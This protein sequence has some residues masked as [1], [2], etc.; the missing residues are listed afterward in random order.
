MAQSHRSTGPAGRWLL[1]FAAGSATVLVL[2]LWRGF[3]WSHAVIVGLAVAALVYS[4]WRTWENV[5]R[6]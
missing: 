2:R 3:F 6:S 4:T 5:K 1:A